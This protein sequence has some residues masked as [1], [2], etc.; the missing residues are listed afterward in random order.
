[1]AHD[2]ALREK[3]KEMFVVN[4]FSMDT[5]QT[6]LPEVSRKTLF[7]WRKQDNWEELRRARVVKSSTRRERLEASLDRALDELEVVFDPKLVFAVGK[8]IAALKSSSTFE[9]T[10]ERKA[11]DNRKEREMS[12]DTWKEIEERFGL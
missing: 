6:M 11:K 12:E 7:N 8:I 1:M 10:E 9:F 4:G 2:A 5:I 3:A